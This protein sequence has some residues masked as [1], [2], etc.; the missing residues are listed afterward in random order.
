MKNSNNLVLGLL[1]IISGIFFLLV[2]FDV[3]DIN[4]RVFFSLW[5]VLFFLI[6]IFFLPIKAIF[7]V[8]LMLL[9]FIG[10]SFVYEYQLEKKT[11]SYDYFYKYEDDYDDDEFFDDDDFFADEQPEKP[12]SPA[13]EDSSKSEKRKEIFV[14]PFDRKV[15]SA[16]LKID[17]AAASYILEGT[18]K[19][20]IQIAKEGRVIDYKFLVKETEKD[21]IEVSLYPK[22]HK[23]LNFEIN[24]KQFGK[25]FIRL[26]P[27]PV[28]NIDLNVGAAN[29]EFD[30]LPFKVESLSVEGGASNIE[31]KLGDL[32][33]QTKI[34]IEAGLANVVVLIPET[35]GCQIK[36]STALGGK[37]FVGFTKIEKGVYRTEGFDGAKQKIHIEV[38]AALSGLEIKRY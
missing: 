32:Y 37:N 5:P 3:F 13:I 11:D 16:N 17:C 19:E 28:W 18:T 33:P 10:A 30:L 4:W 1:L 15:Q 6:G 25:F 38:D 24:D 27:D 14:K 20:L 26:N 7:K 9:V 29:V 34:D 2:R 23:E 31:I 35:A 21:E 36:S 8:L 12:I 22:E